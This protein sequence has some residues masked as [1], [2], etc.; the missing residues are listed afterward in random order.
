[1]V[2]SHLS[3]G[4]GRVEVKENRFFWSEG[5]GVKNCGKNYGEQNCG[6]EAD[7][8]KYLSL[9]FLLLLKIVVF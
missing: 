7:T 9:F 4:R 6:C 8:I 1:M 3:R 5:G 2:I